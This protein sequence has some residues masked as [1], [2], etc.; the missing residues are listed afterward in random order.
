MR[1]SVYIAT[2]LDG[3]IARPDGGLD[4]L[5]RV[6]RD[7]EDYGY[8]EFLA[9]VD[10][11]IL[12]RNT[13]D[14]VLGFGEWPFAGKRVIVMSSRAIA[15]TQGERQF[16]GE[17]RTLVEQLEAEGARRAYV[18]GGALIRSWLRAGLIDDL[19]LSIVPIVLGRGLPLFGE[20]PEQALELEASQAYASGLVQ[21]RYRVVR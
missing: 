16:A 2:S 3:F 6:Q 4:W 11:L 10:T 17:P 12:G 18:D 19:T 21:L 1:C 5:A 14:T 8:A 20:L 13:Y 9:G 7:G 15:S